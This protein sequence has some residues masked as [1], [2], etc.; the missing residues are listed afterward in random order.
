M[1]ELSRDE[2]DI[3]VWTTVIGSS[4][5]LARILDDGQC[6]EL[7]KRL[8]ALIAP[9]VERFGW[10]VKAG[11]SELESQ[12][13]GDLIGALGTVANDEPDTNARARIIRRNM[14]RA[15]MTSTAI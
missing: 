6:A 13:R 12:L 4:H 9:A 5:H 8:R 14:K 2:D 1:I 15:P 3:N 11:E 10:S 7:E